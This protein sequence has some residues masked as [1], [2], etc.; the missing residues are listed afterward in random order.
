[1]KPLARLVAPLRGLGS[2][3]AGTTALEFAILAPVFIAMTFGGANFGILL[4]NW[5]A[6]NS[7]A[8]QTAR[9]Q[10][11]QVASL[12]PPT[13]TQVQNHAVS[14]ANGLGV[15]LT[16][17]SV[18]ASTATQTCNSDGTT[19]FYVVTISKAI[20]LFIPGGSSL[21]GMVGVSKTYMPTITACYPN[22]QGRPSAP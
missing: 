6:L 8:E 7:A 14:V 18:T 15:S 5:I 20:S 2:S 22:Q 11:A 1:M 12:S 3:R 9:W 21:V 16:A 17:A 13:T 10:A 19:A 4:W